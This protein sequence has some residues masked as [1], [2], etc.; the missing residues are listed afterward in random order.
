M[1]VIVA[2][3]SGSGKSTVGEELAAR[4]GWLYTDG[5]S[6]HP[7]ENIA[8]M[9]AGIPLTDAD[10]GPWLGAIGRLL[11]DRLGAGEQAVLAC[12]ALKRS[13]RDVLLGGRP[14]VV[15]AFLR[16]SQEL[17]AERLAGRHGHFFDP[18]LLASQFADL[19]PPGPDEPSVTAVPVT[20]TPAEVVAGIVS[21]LGLR[22]GLRRPG[23]G[24]GPA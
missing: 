7:P 12:S 3:V 2:G 11:D 19:E 13:Y 15:M 5:D 18:H 20:G 9:S 16:I 1:I 24:P 8:K 4:L 10:R 6:L 14:E 17:A 21:R 23:P 22:P